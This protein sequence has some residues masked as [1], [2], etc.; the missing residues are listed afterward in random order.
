MEQ[1]LLGVDR[2]Y[3]GRCWRIT[4]CT[5][6]LDGTYAERGVGPVSGVLGPIASRHLRTAHR[7]ESASN[8]QVVQVDVECLQIFVVQLGEFLLE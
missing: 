4:A 1:D 7:S 6:S 3:V 8:I 5:G 2:R